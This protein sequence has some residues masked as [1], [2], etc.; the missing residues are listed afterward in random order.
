MIRRSAF[1]ALSRIA[2]ALFFLATS[3]YCL[4]SYSAFAYQQFIRPH[5][6]SALADFTV[7][8][9]LLYWIVLLG[10]AVTLFLRR[11]TALPSRVWIFLGASAAIG[12]WLVVGHVLPEAE[13]SSRSLVL[14]VAALL[15]PIWLAVIDHL[16]I[17]VEPAEPSDSGRL[18][19][20]AIVAALI[21]WVTYAAASP[22]RPRPS[23]AM[24]I[25]GRELALGASSSAIAHLTVF[26]VFVLIAIAIR[27]L[28]AVLKLRP[29]G[30]Y[31][32]LVV[33]SGVASALVVGRMIFAPIAFRGPAAWLVASLAGALIALTWSSIARYRYAD[34]RSPRPTAMDVWFAPVSS[35]AGAVIPL[36]GL[37]MVPVLS[38]VLTSR[39]AIFDWNFMVQELVALMVWLL[40]FG[41]VHAAAGGREARGDR[42]TTLVAPLVV[43]VLFCAEGAVM[44]RLADWM[45]DPRLRADFVLDGYAALDPSYKLIRETITA[46]PGADPVFYS[47]LRANST[48]DPSVPV[49]PADVDFVKPL[50]PAGGFK[51]HIFFFIIDSLRPD[52]ISAYNPAVS[53]TPRLGEFAADSGTHLFS[54]A[55]SRYGGTGLSVPSIWAGGMVLHKEYVTP[56]GPMNALEKLVTVNGYQ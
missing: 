53:F 23:G 2:S 46:D 45:R 56:F 10:T 6:I 14:A 12:V 19:A 34:A 35:S 47:Y 25:A 29:Q 48:I 31:A 38:F 43:L 32:L 49:K 33:A 17:R 51:P 7:W 42:R 36:A 30:E 24:V 20:S 39:A 50:A 37:L 55:F 54:H 52:Y 21:A 40:A 22:F 28:A 15:P 16:A 13:N 18:L 41:L 1:I 26:M 3:L 4:L 8:H 11:S 5:L 9:G 27:E 44:P